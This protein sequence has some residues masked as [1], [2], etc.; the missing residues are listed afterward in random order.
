MISPIEESDPARAESVGAQLDELSPYE[1]LLGHIDEVL[2]EWREQVRGEPW[3]RIPPARLVDAFP[4]ILPP[5]IRLA[6]AGAVHIDDDL[7]SRITEDHGFFRRQDEIPLLAVAE[8]WSFLKRA[9]ARVLD[10]RGIVSDEIGRAVQRLETLI[11]DAI[12]YTL[13]GYYRPELDV[14]RG[15]G[16]ERRDSGVMDRRSGTAD[17]RESGE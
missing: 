13:R 5:L 14:L 4:Q 3:A 17:R 8:E 7:K 15:R 2:A 12:G 1:V 10:R 11:D 6:R 16:L 9:C